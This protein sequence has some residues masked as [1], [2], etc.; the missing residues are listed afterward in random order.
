MGFRNDGSSHKTGVKNEII[1][2]EKIEQDVLYAS[3]TIGTVIEGDY[4]VEHIGGTKGKTDVNI[5]VNGVTRRISIKKKEDAKSG[6]FDWINTTKALNASAKYKQFADAVDQ[7]R[8]RYRPTGNRNAA[9]EMINEASSKVLDT[10]DHKDIFPILQNFVATPYIQQQLRILVN[11]LQDGVNYSFDFQDM[12]LCKHIQSNSK[13]T[14]KPPS[15]G[16]T[17]T[18]R[19]VLF[20]GEDIGIRIRLVTNNGISALVGKSKANKDA[21][22]TVKIQQDKVATMLDTTSN[23]RKFA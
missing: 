22:A 18:S 7:A 21:Q 2:K 13:I 3:N 12:E 15:R 17:Q 14:L 11:D 1:V 20:D 23:V 8:K 10:L 16:N 19:I 6:S 5:V 9:E 4:Q